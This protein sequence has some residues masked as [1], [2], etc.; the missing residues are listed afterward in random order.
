LLE[1]LELRLELKPTGR[2]YTP[3]V[4]PSQS[5]Q[6][7]PFNSDNLLEDLS[8]SKLS[9]LKINFQTGGVRLLT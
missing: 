2:V 3:L 1:G 4:L 5:N 6:R 8:Q 7:T 9:E